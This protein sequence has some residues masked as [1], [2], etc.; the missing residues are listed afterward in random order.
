MGSS[1]NVHLLETQFLWTAK[2]SPSTTLC[3]STLCSPLRVQP[4]QSEQ[5]T[6]GCTTFG[7][8]LSLAS[9]WGLVEVLVR[10]LR[11]PSHL[12]YESAMIRDQVCFISNK[13]GCLLTHPLYAIYKPDPLAR[14]AHL[15]PP[16]SRRLSMRIFVQLFPSKE[17]MRVMAPAHPIVAKTGFV[18]FE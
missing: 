18:Q 6:T 15:R 14:T 8:A 7:Q 2:V 4:S 9:L 17:R 10:I 3:W 13:G 12:L 1:N 11:T 16:P 5:L